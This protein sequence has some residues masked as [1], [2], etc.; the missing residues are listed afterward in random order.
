[1]EGGYAGLPSEAV[2][3]VSNQTLYEKTRR[4]YHDS[5]IKSLLIKIWKEFHSVGRRNVHRN[6]LGNYKHLTAPP[7]LP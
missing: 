4:N 5:I 7:S 1:M 6:F 2:N 3:T